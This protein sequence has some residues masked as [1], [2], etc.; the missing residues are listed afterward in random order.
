MAGL[1]SREC[2]PWLPGSREC[3]P[4]LPCYRESSPWITGSEECSPLL[5]NSRE[6]PPWLP[7]SR[8]CSPS[9]PSSRVL[10]LAP[11]FYRVLSLSCPR[12][13]SLRSPNSLAQGGGLG[14]GL[15]VGK[16]GRRRKRNTRKKIRKNINIKLEWVA[17][18]VANPQGANST[19]RQIPH[20]C[21]PLF[22]TI[23]TA[24]LQHWNSCIDVM[25][26]LIHII[27]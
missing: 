17:L 27:Q 20:I 7:G 25:V 23:V 11:C 16:K 12:G 4:W 19:T 22:D 8:E 18:F 6:F 1:G 26:L 10:S 21:N 15:R 13:F 2:S 5:P 14:A 24:N 9:L 3:S